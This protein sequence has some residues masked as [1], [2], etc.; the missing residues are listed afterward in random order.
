ML[1]FFF[2]SRRRHTRCGRDWSS[3][4][5][6][7]DLEGVGFAIPSNT[8]SSIAAQLISN[9]KAE[10]AFL[11]VVLRDSSSQTGAAISQVRAGTPAAGASLRAGDIVTSAAGTRINSAS[12]LR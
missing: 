3:D 8:V 2:S 7:S 4:V 1:L 5:C 12:E 10:H 9:G 6:S 11:G